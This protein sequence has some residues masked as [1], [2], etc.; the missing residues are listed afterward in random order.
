M[1]KLSSEEEKE[2]IVFIK[3]WLKSHGYSQK[4]LAAQ[5]RI[6]SSRTSE[7]TKK[8]KDLYKRGGIINIVKN[9]IKIEQYWIT[10]NNNKDNNNKD[11]NKKDNNNNKEYYYSEENKRQ[12]Y[13]QLD[14]NYKLDLDEL[15]DQMEKD[16]KIN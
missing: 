2:L 16:H 12:G 10:I 13:N 14:L 4:D 15:M 11:N 9:L 3:D 5:L 1:N 7:I 8:M 6:R